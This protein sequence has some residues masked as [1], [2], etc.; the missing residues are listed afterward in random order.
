KQPVA[1]KGEPASPRS[2][3]AFAVVAITLPLAAGALYWGI[4][5]FPWKNPEAAS[6]VPA[7]HGEGE[8]GSLADA[9]KQLEARMAANPQDAEGWQ[10]LGRS[11]LVTGQ[12]GKAVTAYEKA[13]AIVGGTDPGLKLDL[14]EAL[15][16][17]DD[18]S[19][20]A[21]A[22]DIIDATLE[23]DPNSGKALWY[24]GVLAMRRG[25]KD[26]AKAAFQK[27]LEQNPP[28]QIRQ[29]VVEQLAG[30]G[31][32]VPAAEGEGASAMA[33]SAGAQ[34]PESGVTAAGRTVRV[35]ISVDPSVAA[36]LK[37]GMPLF[38]AARE[39]GI[40]GPPLA[41]VRLSSDQLPTTVV[42]SD[43]NSMVEGRNLSSVDT[44]EIVAHVAIGGTPTVATGD[45][46]GQVKNSKGGPTD[47]AIVIN[48]VAP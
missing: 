10:M 31:V 3:S 5:N 12:A 9:V 6:A 47:V 17:T 44:V 18:P 45:L 37:P 24:S 15:V 11:Y 34:T 2:T 21:R 27:L 30:L 26:T 13:D 29:I 46:V 16:L 19:L 48:Q 20:Q 1:A 25:D 40:P 7:G 4:T 33:G 35:A 32:Q 28:P 8:A 36:K 22:K 14:A 39:P 43:A 38:V 41:A 23:S 42:L